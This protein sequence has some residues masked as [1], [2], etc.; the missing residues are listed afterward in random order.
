[1]QLSGC[2]Q[3]CLENIAAAPLLNISFGRWKTSEKKLVSNTAQTQLKKT[4]RRW[5]WWWWQ[6][7][8]IIILISNNTKRE[9]KT[10]SNI[11]GSKVPFFH[12]SHR[13]TLQSVLKQIHCFSV[14][15]RR[16]VLHRTASLPDQYYC[17]IV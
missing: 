15:T 17:F 7:Y 1:M 16:G 13:I 9:K 12:S 2:F 10:Q 5:R 4:L 6:N 11:V 8:W 14:T 3:S